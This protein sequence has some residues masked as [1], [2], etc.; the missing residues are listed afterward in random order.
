M[1]DFVTSSRTSNE[2]KMAISEHLSNL[3]IKEFG[4]SP[5]TIESVRVL[6]P[7]IWDRDNA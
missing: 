6:F 2:L 5:H 4:S 1:R 3:L 7:K